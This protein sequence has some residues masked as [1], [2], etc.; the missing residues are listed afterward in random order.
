MGKASH[1]RL[2]QLPSVNRVANKLKKSQMRWWD[3]KETHQSKR[4]S[5]GTPQ[6]R[7]WFLQP[8]CHQGGEVKASAPGKDMLTVSSLHRASSAPLLP[9]Q[10]LLPHKRLT[11]ESLLVAS[12]GLMQ[13]T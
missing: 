1:H 13:G 4:F 7:Q 9:F 8:P 11:S 12:P 3:W 10:K 5:N 2:P 6:Q